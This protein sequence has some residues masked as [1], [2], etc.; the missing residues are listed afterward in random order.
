MFVFVVKITLHLH[1]ISFHLVRGR[2][3]MCRIEKL[4]HY[5]RVYRV[6]TSSEFFIGAWF[7]YKLTL[8]FQ[9]QKNENTYSWSLI[10]SI[11]LFYRFLFYLH[12]FQTLINWFSLF[13]FKANGQLFLCSFL[14]AQKWEKTEMKIN[15]MWMYK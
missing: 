6:C 9:T 12:Y 4:N 5:V 14:C 8:Y 7:F 3:I 2:L 13:L 11:R 15:R 1:R 10:F